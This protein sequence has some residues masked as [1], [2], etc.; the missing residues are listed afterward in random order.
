MTIRP[1]DL[2]GKTIARVLQD[3]EAVL[4]SSKLQALSMYEVSYRNYYIEL[5][6]GTVFQLPPSLACLPLEETSPDRRG[7]LLDFEHER[8]G[9]YLTQTLTDVLVSQELDG[10]F[11][12]LGN[13]QVLWVELAL[14]ATLSLGPRSF[15]EENNEVELRSLCSPN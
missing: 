6:D 13:G 1:A 11:F 8:I 4:G 14:G 2:I 12:G 5:S 9:E 15:I 3:P 10:V 7:K